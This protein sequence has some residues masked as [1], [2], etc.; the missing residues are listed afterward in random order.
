MN[1]LVLFLTFLLSKTAVKHPYLRITASAFLGALVSAFML[2]RL[3]YGAALLGVAFF[4]IPVMLWG[5]F[6]KETIKHYLFRMLVSWFSIVL[7]NGV[8]TALYNLTG[9]KALH[10]YSCLVVFAVAASLAAS[11]ITGMKRQPK[12]LNVHILHHGRSVECIGFYD[13]GNLLTIPE[14]GEPV[15]LASQELLQQ[16]T[17]DETVNREIPFRAL[18]TKNGRISVYQMEEIKIEGMGKKN[19][20]EKKGV[21][22]GIAEP[23]LLQGKDYQVI[24]NAALLERF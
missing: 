9:I 7:L 14:T 6:G 10:L 13:S 3:P 11:G 19:K 4:V 8:V 21:W 24:L 18:G 17:D 5:S 1:F 12:R 15:C 20:I 23:G 22:F 2:I 16:V